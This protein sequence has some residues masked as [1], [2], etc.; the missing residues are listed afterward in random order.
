MKREYLKIIFGAVLVIGLLILLN[1]VSLGES[2]VSS[3]I[4]RHGGSM[5]TGTYQIYLEQS[6]IKYRFIGSILALLGGLGLIKE[7]ALNQKFSKK[8]S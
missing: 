8:I 3:I 4:N 7:L 5:D 2:A 1:S 6:I